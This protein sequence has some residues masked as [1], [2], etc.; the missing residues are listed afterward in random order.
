MTW[1]ISRPRTHARQS[2]TSRRRLQLAS[3]RAVSQSSSRVT[4]TSAEYCLRLWLRNAVGASAA[5]SPAA[6][7]ATR[8]SRRPSRYATTALSAPN[9]SG[10]ARSRS[11]GPT[12]GIRRSRRVQPIGV[13]EV[14]SRSWWSGARTES[15]T[16]PS[17]RKKAWENRY[18]GRRATTASGRSKTMR[19]PSI[20]HRD[21][22]GGAG[23]ASSSTSSPAGRVALTW[24][25][26]AR[27][28]RTRTAGSASSF[29]SW[30]TPQR[31]PILTFLPVGDAP[32]PASPGRDASTRVPRCARMSR[33][34]G[35]SGMAIREPSG[36]HP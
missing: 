35:P 19:L 17:S 30:I 1:L 31:T 32:D 5:A 25:A 2:T 6:T 14:S 27:G 10:R 7:A 18:P 23:S 24:G 11:G 28:T 16:H 34:S 4:K 29:P 9:A 3:S 13:D 21:G 36:N 22:F 33:A 12:S 26:Q 20:H 8:P 15:A